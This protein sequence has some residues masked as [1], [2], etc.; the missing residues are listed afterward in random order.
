MTAEKLKFTY[1]KDTL[2]KLGLQLNELAML[3]LVSD[4]TLLSWLNRNSSIPRQY[5][6][7]VM[8]INKYEQLYENPNLELVYKNWET[9]RK[10]FLETPKKDAL[11]KLQLDA[12]KNELT[13]LKMNVKKNKLLQRLHFSENY[14]ACVDPVLHEDENLQQWINVLQR[15]SSLDLAETALTIQKLE[16]KKAALTAQIQY[17]E[18]RF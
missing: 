10:D 11:R 14:L 4:R 15:S 16:V 6:G 18:G 3:L 17:W 1:M 12:R 13:L 8:G 7:Y 2:Y 5:S 9:K